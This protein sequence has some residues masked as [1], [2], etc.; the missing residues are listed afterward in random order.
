M[1]QKR[2]PLCGGRVFFSIRYDLMSRFKRRRAEMTTHSW[3]G[4]SIREWTLRWFW[5]IKWAKTCDWDL[6]RWSTID[7]FG[8]AFFGWYFCLCRTT[9]K[10]LAMLER[11]PF[12]SISLKPFPD[13]FVVIASY[14]ANG[15]HTRNNFF[16]FFERTAKAAI[17]RLPRESPIVAFDPLSPKPISVS[18]QKSRHHVVWAVATK[19]DSPLWRLVVSLQLDI[20]DFLLH[21]WRVR[22]PACF[23]L[24]RV[25][26]FNGTKIHMVTSKSDW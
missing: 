19:V 26:V 23:A 9:F 14:L 16:F 15:V 24:V 8:S 20:L 11:N 10:L 7:C 22:G 2:T 12:I 21:I 6:S 17:N 4:L 1:E 18:I 25:L 5:A 3:D 13:I